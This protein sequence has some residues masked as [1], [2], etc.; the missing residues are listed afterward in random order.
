MI[1]KSQERVNRWSRLPG[2]GCCR[3]RT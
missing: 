1:D 2:T 3:R